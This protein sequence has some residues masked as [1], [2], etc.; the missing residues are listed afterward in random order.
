MYSKKMYALDSS[1]EKLNLA[2]YLVNLSVMSLGLKYVDSLHMTNYAQN[3][4]VQ[5]SVRIPTQKTK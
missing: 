5:N 2:L 1:P 3:D 4:D